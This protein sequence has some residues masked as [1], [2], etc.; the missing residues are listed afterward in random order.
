MDNKTLAL[1]V[2]VFLQQPLL[3]GQDD[4]EIHGD[5]IS[6]DQVRK[7][8]RELDYPEVLT[9]EQILNL[10]KQKEFQQEVIIQKNH[11]QRGLIDGKEMLTCGAGS[12]GGDNDP[13]P[14]LPR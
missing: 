3:G 5:R 8:L 1:I 12:H 4:H 6:F 11:F 2:L 7:I 9:D 10:V 13:K 14:I